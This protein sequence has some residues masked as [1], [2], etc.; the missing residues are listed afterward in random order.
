MYTLKDISIEKGYTNA[1]TGGVSG[2]CCCERI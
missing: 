2:F 1:L